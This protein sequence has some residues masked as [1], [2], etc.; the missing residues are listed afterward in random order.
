[1]SRV[2]QTV[3]QGIKEYRFNESAHEL[4][5]FIWHEF[6]DWYLEF[7]KPV[8]VSGGRKPGKTE[9]PADPLSGLGAIL[10][11]SSL[12]ALYQRETLSIPSGRGHH[13]QRTFS[14]GG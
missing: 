7:I 13:S 10:N 4:Y 12:H 9:H 1:M 6:C 14:G 8:L 3:E 5:Q 2:I 11:W